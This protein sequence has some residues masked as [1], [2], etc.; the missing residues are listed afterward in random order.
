MRPNAINAQAIIWA[1]TLLLML[2]AGWLD[3]RSR[4]IPNWLTVSGF[5][6][7]IGVHIWISGWHGILFSLEGA[8]LAL[9]VLLPLV[10]LRALGAGDWKLMGAAGAFVG[11]VMLLFVLLASFVI[12]AFMGMVRMMKDHRVITTLRNM[13]DLVRGFVSFGL[14]PHPVI[15]LDNPELPKLPFGVAAAIGTIVCYAATRL[16]L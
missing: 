10:L 11:P 13:R 8:A 2:S 14:R 4:R 3:L 16:V 9:A 6:A 12:A 7:G 1:L 15:S 5:L